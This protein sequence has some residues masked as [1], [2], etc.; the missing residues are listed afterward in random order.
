MFN[1]LHLKMLFIKKE[2]WGYMY[3]NENASIYHIGQQ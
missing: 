3:E 1:L 2:K